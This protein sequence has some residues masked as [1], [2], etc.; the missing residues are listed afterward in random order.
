M[1]CVKHLIA[2]V[3]IPVLYNV[4]CSEKNGNS[5]G[6]AASGAAGDVHSTHIPAQVI[7]HAD[8]SGLSTPVRLAKT[9]K[10]LCFRVGRSFWV[11]RGYYS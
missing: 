11:C 7:P 4:R 1:L 5:L 8:G 3:I 2:L 9:A 6:Q 10:L